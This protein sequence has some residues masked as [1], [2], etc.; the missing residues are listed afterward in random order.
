MSGVDGS[1]GQPK[2]SKPEVLDSTPSSS[3]CSIVF[4]KNLINDKSKHKEKYVT[5][6][7]ILSGPLT[8]IYN[9]YKSITS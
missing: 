3:C 7:I 5:I 4:I 2:A 9:M 1:V 8:V 6:C